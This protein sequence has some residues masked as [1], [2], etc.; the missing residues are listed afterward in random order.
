MAEVVARVDDC[1]NSIGSH[2]LRQAE[3]ELC[4]SYSAGEDDDIAAHWK[5]SSLSGRSN[6]D[7]GKDPAGRLTPRMSAAGT[8]SAPSPIA[9]PAALAIMSATA[10]WVTSSGRPS[11]S[12]SPRLSTSDGRP[13]APRATLTPP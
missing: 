2:D 1:G 12:R 13:L 10:I 11:R 6:A 3:H 8:P 5:R 7:A 9:S 4:A